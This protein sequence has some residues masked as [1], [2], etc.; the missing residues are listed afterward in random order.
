MQDSNRIT[1]E[2]DGAAGAG[3]SA[4][5]RQLLRAGPENDPWT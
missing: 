2:S 5:A 1:I 4:K 3:S